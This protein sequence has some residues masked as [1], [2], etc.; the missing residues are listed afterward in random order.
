VTATNKGTQYNPSILISWSPV[1]NATSYKVFRSS[2]S[3]G[4]YSQIGS[5]TSNTYMYDDSPLSGS[6]YYKVK[7][8]N[9]AGESS[10]SSYAFY[11][12]DNNVEYSPCPPTVK[13]SGTTS[14]T[15]T[16]TNSTSAGC[17]KPTSYEV[18][19]R[20]PNTGE[21]ELKKTT[22]STSYSPTSS[23]IHP[24]KNMYAIKAINNSGSDRGQAYSQDVPLAKPSSFTAQ[25]SGTDVKFT[26]SKVK[27]ATGYQIFYGTSANGNYYALDQITDGD[28]TSLTRSYPASSGTTHYFKIRAY[29][30][31][32]WITL[33]TG[34]FST[35]KSVKF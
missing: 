12:N 20:N 19:K 23:D 21:Y 6:N 17:G 26:W 32:S 29:F 11:N 1:S 9:N 34:E 22:S 14:Q 28:Q 15:V 3:G 4:S 10:Y 31:C 35:Y 25:K 30:E 18:Y 24:G 5:S 16:W 8:V 7:A 2:S 13:V 33:Y 27:W